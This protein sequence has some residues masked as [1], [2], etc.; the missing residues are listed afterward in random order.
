MEF[1]AATCHRRWEYQRFQ[2]CYWEIALYT[3]GPLR[4][5]ERSAWPYGPPVPVLLEQV[6]PHLVSIIEQTADRATR[7]EETGSRS[8][9]DPKYTS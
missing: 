4:R 6:R 7:I 5:L 3:D 2:E 8:M 9:A 1:F